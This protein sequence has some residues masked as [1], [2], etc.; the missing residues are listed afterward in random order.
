MMLSPA[1]CDI[2]LC[3]ASWWTIL[4]NYLLNQDTLA[5]AVA[6]E[7]QKIYK[8][9]LGPEPVPLTVPG[10]AIAE[11]DVS[12][13]LFIYTIIGG[14]NPCMTSVIGLAFSIVYFIFRCIFLMWTM[15]VTMMK[16]LLKMRVKMKMAHWRKSELS[17]MTSWYFPFT[18]FIWQYRLPI[19]SNNIL[20]YCFLFLFSLLNL[21]LDIQM[22]INGCF[23]YLLN[24]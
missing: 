17:Y 21:N 4:K 12:L 1:I 3:Y 9:E 20:F 14:W 5:S 7:M 18:I 2:F 13:I 24:L 19:M 23:K 11:E 15:G 6:E 16:V 10:E 22:H 8:N